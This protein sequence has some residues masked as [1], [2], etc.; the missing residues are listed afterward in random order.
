ML[1]L[2]RFLDARGISTKGCA[3]ILGV[4]EKTMYNKLTEETEF[5]YGEVRKLKVLLPEYDMD[6]LLSKDETAVA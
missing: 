3:E 6:Y 4:S 5:T 2:K 1:R